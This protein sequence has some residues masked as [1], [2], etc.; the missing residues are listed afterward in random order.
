MANCCVEIS[1]KEEECH[2]TASKQKSFNRVRC[3][4][5]RLRLEV[6]VEEPELKHYQAA[7]PSSRMPSPS[8]SRSNNKTEKGPSFDLCWKSGELNATMLICES[9]FDKLPTCF[10]SRQARN[11]EPRDENLV[12]S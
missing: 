5:H 7:K 12:V 10:A 2:G 4:V 8:P 1:C 6:S 9:S 11:V 3:S